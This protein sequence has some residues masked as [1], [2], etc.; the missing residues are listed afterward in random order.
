LL[1]QQDRWLGSPRQYQLA[2]QG[3]A[4]S[5]RQPDERTNARLEARGLLPL[6]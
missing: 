5:H 1:E 4:Y 6:E 2:R 3:S